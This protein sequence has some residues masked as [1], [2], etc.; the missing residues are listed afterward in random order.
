MKRYTLNSNIVL[1]YDVIDINEVLYFELL[2]DTNMIYSGKCQAIPVLNKYII[3]LTQIIQT[4]F[5]NFEQ[6]KLIEKSN[7]V[8]AD[9]FTLIE[10]SKIFKININYNNTNISNQIE[11]IN[12]YPINNEHKKVN[13]Y[14]INNYNTSIKE[15]FR[16]DKNFGNSFNKYNPLLITFDNRLS[17]DFD[18]IEG[19]KYRYEVIG[20]DDTGRT[21][22]ET[23]TNPIDNIKGKYLT[24]VLN[25]NNLLNNINT[26]NLFQIKL[27]ID[28]SYKSL[29][30]DTFFVNNSCHKDKTGYYISHNGVAQQVTF[31]NITSSINSTRDNYT[32]NIN[33]HPLVN[34]DLLFNYNVSNKLNN[35]IEYN[36]EYTLTTLPIV[37]DDIYDLVTS[38]Y[39]IVNGEELTINS[40]SISKKY[41]K[42][43]GYHNYSINAI[44]YSKH[45]IRR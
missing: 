35:K 32:S 11:V 12:S 7:S 10:F 20:Y 28:M 18:L 40:E 44:N 27:F 30:F 15:L 8:N 19:I 25:M 16:F 5:N 4:Q 1:T 38:P 6:Q 43:D 45:N 36:I 13:D 23:M 26:I 22:I 33:S 3:D 17:P 42:I 9:I 37:F 31:A 24:F 21:I 29:I 14:V 34:N 41:F 39:L 2:F